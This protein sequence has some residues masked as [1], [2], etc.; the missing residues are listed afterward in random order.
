MYKAL[1]I[2]LLVLFL[3]FTLLAQDDSIPK[4][5]LAQVSFFY[6][7][8]SNGVKSYEKSNHFSLNI[9]YGVN[10]GVKGTEVGSVCNIN[11]G[12]VAGVQ[13]AGAAN[14]N[15]GNSSGSIVAGVSNI[16]SGSFAGSMIA[17]VL[18]FANLK[19]KGVQVATINLVT[20]SL[21]GAQIGVINYAKQLKG[22]QVGVLNLGG[23]CDDCIPIGLINIFKNGFHAFEIT[24]GELI[25]ANLQ[26]KVGV[27]KFYNIFKVGLFPFQDK[28]H[29]TYG[30]GFGSF[31]KL[32]DRHGFSA[33]LT[34]NAILFDGKWESD[35]NLLNKMDLNYRLN[36]SNHVSFV[37]GPTFNVYLTKEIIDG[38]YGTIDIPYSLYD[39]QW[40]RGK[41]SGWI[42]FNAG[43]SFVL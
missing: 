40:R 28:M 37:A 3:S 5:G 18:N 16:N 9:I 1:I 12:N 27:E 15:K 33:D 25:Y 10:G 26:Y 36:L 21:Q 22:V 2:N 17:G 11:K 43:I 8:G 29:F 6:P 14:V 34:S 42:G 20:D 39:H 32:N 4:T 38:Q 19:S 24:T 13:V 23:S 41:L 7:V 35:L 31:F 30:F